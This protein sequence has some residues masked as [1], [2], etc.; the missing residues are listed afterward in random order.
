MV[1]NTQAIKIFNK[2]EMVININIININMLRRVQNI[3]KINI[4]FKIQA[5]INKINLTDFPRNKL[6]ID[7]TIHP[8]FL[9]QVRI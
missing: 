3:N 2:K 8:R 4:I 7:I 5:I 1:N 9:K 6:I